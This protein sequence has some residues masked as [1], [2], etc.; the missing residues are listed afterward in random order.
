M[1][2]F[3]LLSLYTSARILLSFTSA[4]CLFF[5]V[6]F[7]QNNKCIFWLS[8]FWGPLNLA[9]LR[10]SEGRSLALITWKGKAQ[11]VPSSSILQNLWP[12]FNGVFGR[13]SIKILCE[14]NQ[15]AFPDWVVILK[16]STVALL[17]VIVGVTSL[18]PHATKIIFEVLL[19]VEINFLHAV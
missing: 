5:N 4:S 10:T 9:R 13:S 15:F 8:N 19:T 12:L 2:S 18:L 3:A 16:S 6:P 1:C 11:K 17:V 14:L 7:S